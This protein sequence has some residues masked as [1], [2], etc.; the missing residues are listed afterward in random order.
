MPV[1]SWPGV[2]MP[3]N[4]ILLAVKNPPTSGFH[5]LQEIPG[6]GIP[7]IPRETRVVLVSQPPNLTMIELA[8]ALDADG[9]LALPIS[10]T[11]VTNTL[12]KALKRERDLKPKED[13]LAANLP[14]PVR[15]KPK[16][17]SAK[18]NGANAAVIWTPKEK[19]KAEFMR[20]LE[21]VLKKVSEEETVEP[22]KIVN[23]RT[24]W[25]KDLLPGM[26][27]AEDVNGEGDDLL[28]AA[29][30]HLNNFLIE[31]IKQFS[32]FGLCRSFLKAGSAP[33]D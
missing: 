13:Y 24:F 14:R 21:T 15:K 28:L 8:G 2:L 18:P 32:E 31:K 26:I 27:L 5:I 4:I 1:R 29:G 16:N 30:T 7:R 33:Q 11:T 20:S 25:L 22:A 10:A 17:D 23:I 3:S 6:G 12:S 19:E 9:F